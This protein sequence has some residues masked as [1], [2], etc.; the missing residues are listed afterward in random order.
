[1]IFELFSM[2]FVARC[3]ESQLEFKLSFGVYLV[4]DAVCWLIDCYIT[5]AVV[6]VYLLERLYVYRVDGFVAP[7]CFSA[8]ADCISAKSHALIIP[9]LI[10]MLEK[11]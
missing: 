10:K 1:M 3:F 2:I 7:M 11:L 4:S 8:M 6:E 5:L 9:S